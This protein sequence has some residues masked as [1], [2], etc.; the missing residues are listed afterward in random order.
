MV[1]RMRGDWDYE[2]SVTVPATWKDTALLHLVKNRFTETTPF[3]VA[4]PWRSSPR[5]IAETP[6]CG[7]FKR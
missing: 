6:I 5:K 2:Y 4:I 3:R 1:E 7:S